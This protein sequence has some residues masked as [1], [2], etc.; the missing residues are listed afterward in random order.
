MPVQE[1]HEVGQVGV[2]IDATGAD[3]AHQVHAHRI[4]AEREERAVAERE[5]AAIAPDEIERQGQERVAQ[6]FADQRENVGR[7]VEGRSGRYRERQDRDH[8]RG[9]DHQREEHEAP[10]VE[11]R[12]AQHLRPPRRGP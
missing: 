12:V 7:H 11:V 9:P 10:P 8:D 1:H 4:A 2:G 6:V 5:N 3:L